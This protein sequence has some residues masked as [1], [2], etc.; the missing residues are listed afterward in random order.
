MANARKMGSIEISY[1]ANQ[2]PFKD[3]TKCSTLRRTGSII[4]IIQLTP[5]SVVLPKAGST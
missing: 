5:V 1:L 3:E 2:T 4:N